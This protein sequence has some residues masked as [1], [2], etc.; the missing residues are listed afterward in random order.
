MWNWVAVPGDWLTRLVVQRGLAGIYLI[1]FLVAVNQ[2]RPLL[3]EHG[4]LPAPAY[5]RRTSFRE[6]PSLFHWRYSDQLLLAVAWTGVVVAGLAVLGITE[7]GPLWVSML[8]WALLWVLYLSIVNIG[9]MF[10]GFG[11]ESLLLE[12]GFLAVFL[13]SAD[14][15]PPLP[16]LLLMRWLVFRLELGAG[17]IKLR[18]DRCWR[19]L[20]CLNH[21]HETQPMPGP[22]SRWFHR[23]PRRVH[24][25]EVLANHVA[26]LVV[27][28]GLLLPQ[29]V[30]GIAA[31]LL[32]VTQLWLVLSGNFS[33]LNAVTIVLTCAA[34]S[35]S[36]LDAVLPVSP[37]ETLAMP[38]WFA[39]ASLLLTAG[40]AALSWQPVRNMA[41]GGQV[42]NQSFNRYH[43]V[44]TY[45]AFG[46]VTRDRFEVI[47]EATLD[48]RPGP[49]SEWRE[50]EFKGKPGDPR[51]RPPQ[52]APYHLR[53]DWML[54]FVALSPAY[55][56]AWFEPFLIKLLQHDPAVRKLLRSV[57]FGQPPAV[58]RARL[59]RYRFADTRA[60]RAGDWWTRSLITELFPAV[61][62]GDR[63]G[64]PVLLPP[65]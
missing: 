37:P 50:F 5:L 10:Y 16:V 44:N 4:L 24:K 59:Y 41:S 21:H 56:G 58:V 49:D 34:L 23:L 14:V 64:R 3:G 30:A 53:L 18:G 32:I 33:W 20:T 25:A 54:W 27:P 38:A 12:A 9:Q 28:F 60:R 22:L 6:S 46:T 62:L 57:P 55:A 42:M 19:D 31:V 65:G 2:F 47:I 26:Q 39:A 11:W 7:S 52:I 15:A 1:A 43:L 45:G 29:P 35:G 48:P 40:V 17:L 63:D 13:G 8:A 36:Q 61:R 51:R